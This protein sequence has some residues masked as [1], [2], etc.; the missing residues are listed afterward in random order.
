MYNLGLTP[1]QAK[2]QAGAAGGADAGLQP[3]SSAERE[4]ES[5]RTMESECKLD[6]SCREGDEFAALLAST[7]CQGCERLLLRPFQGCPTHPQY[8]TIP[9]RG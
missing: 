1:M 5:C 2:A 9:N 8:P 4:P 3:S 7:K 6:A